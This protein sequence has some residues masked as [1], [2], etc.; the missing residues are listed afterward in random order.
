M[1]DVRAYRPGETVPAKFMKNL[2]VLILAAGK[3]TRLV[4]NR[5]KVLHSLC[6]TPMLRLVYAAAAGLEPDETLVVIGHDAAR[7]Q[8]SL[9]GHPAGFILQA[10]QLGTGHAVMAAQPQFA[11]HAGDL[12]VLFGDTPRITTPTLRK[13]FDHH[14]RSG[15]ATTLLTT[16][17]PEPFGYGRILRNAQGEIQAIVE[18]KDATPEQRKI[19]EINPGF[20]CFQIPSLVTALGRLSNNNAQKEYYVTDLIEIQRRAGE[21]I[22][23]V[24]HENFEELRGINTRR[25]LAELARALSRQKNLDLMAAGVTLIDPERTYVD[26][27]VTIEKDVTLYPMVTLEGKT[28]IGE[29]TSVRSGTRIANSVIA[30]GVQILDSCVITDSEVGSGTTIGPSARLRDH[31]IIGENCRVGNFVEIKNSRLGKGTKAAHLAYLGDSQ[32]GNRVNIGAGTITCNYDGLKKNATIIEDDAFIGT[33]S[34]LVAPVRIGRGAYVAAG[35]CIT[36]DVPPAALG[37]ARGSQV[38]KEGWAERRKKPE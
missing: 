15:A 14:R 10:E 35:S 29:G 24:L 5:A 25:E 23:T 34:Q 28:H 30:A 1:D 20:Y 7:V 31:T 6:G 9:A 32:I 11:N 2:R 13:L 27:D 18:E 3:G 16:R 22:E 19:D 33:D 36:R 12:L 8:E 4:S 37:I 38:N 26:L 21:K 17:L